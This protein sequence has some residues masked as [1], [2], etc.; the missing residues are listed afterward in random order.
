MSI[1]E[2]EGTGMETEDSEQWEEWGPGGAG[3]TQSVAVKGIVT[4]RKKNP[5]S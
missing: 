5:Y 2:A 3:G 4:Q 1:R